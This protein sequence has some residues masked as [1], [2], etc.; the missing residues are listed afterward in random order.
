M[1]GLYLLGLFRTPHDMP[2]ENISVPRLI[3]AMSFL[4]M[5]GYIGVNLIVGEE[6]KDRRGVLW[7]QIAAFAPPKIGNVVVDK[8]LGPTLVEDGQTYA[9]DPDMALAYAVKLKKPLFIDF[10]GMNCQNCRRM[11]Q[12]PLSTATVH[13]RLK[14]FVLVRA[15]TDTVPGIETFDESQRLKKRNLELQEQWFGDQTLPGYAVVSPTPDA[16]AKQDTIL[17]SW[18]IGFR[19]DAALFAQFLDDGLQRVDGAIAARAEAVPRMAALDA[20]Q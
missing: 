12:G 2:V 6:A 15:Y 1:T 8:E 13:D 16:F 19:N 4:G 17:S 11:E 10:T 18:R 3:L 7:Q 9:L 5:A 20:G 14:N